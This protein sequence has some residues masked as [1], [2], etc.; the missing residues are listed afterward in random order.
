MKCAA[1]AV[2]AFHPN[3]A[4]HHFDQSFG[5]RESE[6][7]TAVL[8]RGGA[9]GLTK[10]LEQPGSL[11][12]GHADSTVTHREPYIHSVPESFVQSDGDHD[13]AALGEF[14]GVVDKVDEDLT[15]PQRIPH[16]IRRHVRLCSDEELQ[17]LVVSFL[18]NHAGDIF[19]DFFKVKICLLHIQLARLDF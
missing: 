1:S 9:V 6:A 18:T 11:F 7:C 8:S 12:G 16:K 14:H 13:F 2:V 15:K 5:N 19:K 17:I 10:R 4:S 3:V